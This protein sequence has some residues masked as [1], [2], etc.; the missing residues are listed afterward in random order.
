VSVTQAADGK[1]VNQKHLIDWHAQT[2]ENSSALPSGAAMRALHITHPC[3]S[4][5]GMEQTDQQ[6]L[7]QQHQQPSGQQHQRMME[8]QH[9]Q[10]MEQQHQQMFEQHHQQVMEQQD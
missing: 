5:S 9:Q 1:S 6:M 3:T 4:A 2:Y 10:T 7:E 8:Q